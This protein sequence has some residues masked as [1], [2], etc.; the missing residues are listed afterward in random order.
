[1]LQP[2]VDGRLRR[3]DQHP[4]LDAA[5]QHP[6]AQQERVHIESAD[7]LPPDEQTGDAVLSKTIGHVNRDAVGALFGE[8]SNLRFRSPDRGHVELVRPLRHL[9]RAR[10][11]VGRDRREADLQSETVHELLDVAC[12]A[13]L[14]AELPSLRVIRVAVPILLRYYG[15]IE[16]PDVL[17]EMGDLGRVFRERQRQH[18][19]L[20]VLDFTRTRAGCRR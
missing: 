11:S 20:G 13:G 16:R 5:P 15:M 8:R 2:A 12:A 9:G 1:M 19:R 3:D 14:L 6:A 18:F 4:V 7:D 10:Q 17:E